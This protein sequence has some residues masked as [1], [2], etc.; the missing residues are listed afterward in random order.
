MSLQKNEYIEIL[1]KVL[2]YTEIL[3]KV[4]R[5]WINRV[6]NG[7]PYIFQ[8]DSGQ[9]WEQALKQCVA[10]FPFRRYSWGRL[11]AMPMQILD[12]SQAPDSDNSSAAAS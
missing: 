3:E 1:E 10:A 8:L 6:C 11:H 5:P 12:P 9:V 7:R 4:V 2:R